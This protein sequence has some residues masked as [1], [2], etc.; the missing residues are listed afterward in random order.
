MQEN[1]TKIEITNEDLQNH[2]I[3]EQELGDE[4]IDW[5]AKAQEL[6]GMAKRKA[7]KLEKLKARIGEMETKLAGFE[8]KPQDKKKEEGLGYAEK[9]YLRSSGI[10][11]DEISLVE[12]AMKESGKDI[13]TLL[14]SKFFQA[15]LKDH[16]DKKAVESAIP[17]TPNRNGSPAS[18]QV[19]YW[20]AKG[21]ELPQGAEN[22]ELRGK[23][24]EARMQRAKTSSQFSDNPIM[25]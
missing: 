2:D 10:S 19:D 6:A 12:S 14:G 17:N 7:T 5:K 13:D 11:A 1:D 22:M 15:E 4:T 8:P 24:V 20:L 21:H 18:T 9:A 3:S 23:I 25:E 16:R